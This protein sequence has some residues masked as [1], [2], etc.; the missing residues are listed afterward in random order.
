ME[1][2]QEAL[3]HLT[4]PFL[5]FWALT[6]M[7]L[8]S[9]QEH[10]GQGCVSDGSFPMSSQASVGISQS[11]PLSDSEMQGQALV[12]HPRD[13]CSQVRPSWPS[14]YTCSSC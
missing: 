11:E 10:G 13:P 14:P 5:N 1:A 9:A 3:L 7:S 12:A 4:T 6:R 8:W 2:S